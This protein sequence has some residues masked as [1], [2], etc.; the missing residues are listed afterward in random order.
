MKVTLI[1]DSDLD[2]K[3]VKVGF[4]WTTF[5]FG[6]FPSLFRG[7]WK[8][9]GIIFLVQF[10]SAAFLAYLDISIDMLSVTVVLDILA[11][12][13]SLVF[14][15]IINKFYIEHL[16]GKGYWPLSEGDRIDLAE[17][18]IKLEGVEAWTKNENY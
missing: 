12:L 18:G 11:W 8:W 1:R 6:F 4:S 5:F 16:I 7:H 17:K 2:R 10:S 14:A 15:L 13:V 9:A 3:E